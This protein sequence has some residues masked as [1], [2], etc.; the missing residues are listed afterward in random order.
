MEFRKIATWAIDD[1]DTAPYRKLAQICLS[2]IRDVAGRF[3]AVRL[4]VLLMQT[5][6]NRAIVRGVVKP[7]HKDLFA[8]IVDPGFRAVAEEA[9][10]ALR[11]H[12]EYLLLVQIQGKG[13]L[14]ALGDR[15]LATYSEPVGR[16]GS[17][18]PDDYFDLGSSA[19]RHLV[20]ENLGRRP[21]GQQKLDLDLEFEEPPDMLAAEEAFRLY[22][23]AG[24]EFDPLPSELA[25]E[26]VNFI[27]PPRRAPMM[28]WT[29]P[30][31]PKWGRG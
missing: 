19:Q 8:Q 23:E 27:G 12:D 24:G 5:E 25:E 13:L 14:L 30:A 15:T 20:E 3:D 26:S 2:D 11:F 28:P 21:F 10:D 4:M 17:A 16:I 22:V 9:F 1:G 6:E 31:K 7:D 18:P 29:I